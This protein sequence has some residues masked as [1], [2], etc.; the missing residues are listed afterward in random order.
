[1]GNSLGEKVGVG[2]LEKNVQEAA[3]RN[4]DALG[5]HAARQGCPL[6]RDHMRKAGKGLRSNYPEPVLS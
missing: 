2:D 1:M 6:G 3:R 5:H 4:G